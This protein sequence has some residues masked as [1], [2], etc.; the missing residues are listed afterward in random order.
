MLNKCVDRI[1][2]SFFVLVVRTHIK[3]PFSTTKNKRA[4]LKAASKED[5]YEKRGLALMCGWAKHTFGQHIIVNTL[6][7]TR[8]RMENDT[9]TYIQ[10]RDDKTGIVERQ[11]KRHK[12]RPGTGC[13]GPM[14]TMPSQ[15]GKTAV[16]SPSCVGMR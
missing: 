12:G 3:P 6:V 9:K 16:G 14:R 11:R 2:L 8:A 10:R 7:K 13:G 4:F 15:S 5:N 1:F